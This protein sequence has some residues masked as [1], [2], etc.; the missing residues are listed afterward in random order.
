MFEGRG[1]GVCV[2][3]LGSFLTPSASVLDTC[4]FMDSDRVET[5]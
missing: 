3:G 1:R 4:I 5:Y 2:T